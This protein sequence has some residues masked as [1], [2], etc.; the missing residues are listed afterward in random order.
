MHALQQAADHLDAGTRDIEI[1]VLRKLILRQDTDDGAAFGE[2]DDLAAAGTQLRH[3]L[4]GKFDARLVPG[5]LHRKACLPIV[6]EGLFLVQEVL[7]HCG[8]RASHRYAFP[9]P[10]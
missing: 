9:I 3:A 5:V 1:E 10:F 4:L 8:R 2:L 6:H 7:L